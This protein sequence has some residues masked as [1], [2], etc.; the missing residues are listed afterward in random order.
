MRPFRPH[1]IERDDA[2]FSLLE[3]LI[4]SVILP[5]VLAAGYLVFTTLS[6]NYSSIAAQSEAS[7][8]AQQAMDTMVR[9]IRQAQEIVDGGGAIAT[10]TPASCS[11]YA[12]LDRDG[13]P[14]KIT[15]YVDGTDLYRA[16]WKASNPVYPYGYVEGPAQRVVNLTTSSAV[17]FTYFDESDPENAVTGAPDPSTISAVG[18]DLSAARPSENG[19]VS[20]DFTTRVKIRAMFDSLQ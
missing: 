19:Q 8:E 4:A 16:V 6:G 20:V 18:I 13:I 3:L 12:D 7:S 14:E 17:V 15:Y 2:G 5:I 11:F 1:G 10:A 9:E